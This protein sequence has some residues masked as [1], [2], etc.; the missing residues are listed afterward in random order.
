MVSKAQ[1]EA[2][3]KYE[4]KVYSKICI[5]LREDRD[6]ISRDEISTAAA[7]AGQSINEFIIDAI[8]DR[9][10][11]SPPEIIP[12]LERVPFTD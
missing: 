7:A 6:G 1:K 11:G 12:E 9:V 4:N 2:T 8:R 5:R 3:T 10:N